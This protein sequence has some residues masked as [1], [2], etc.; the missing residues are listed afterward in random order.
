M[1]TGDRLSYHPERGAEEIAHFHELLPKAQATLAGIDAGFA[2]RL[3]EYVKQMKA[4][5]WLPVSVNLEEE[6]KR[7]LVAVAKAHVQADEAGK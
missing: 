6:G 4:H 3:G 1:Q 5:P 7:R 2:A